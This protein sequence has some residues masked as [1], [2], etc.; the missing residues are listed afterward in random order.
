MQNKK[1]TRIEQ[2]KLQLADCLHEEVTINCHHH[3]PDHRFLPGAVRV[4]VL[5]ELEIFYI[6]FFK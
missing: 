2:L 6:H 3:G 4:V 5:T 1:L